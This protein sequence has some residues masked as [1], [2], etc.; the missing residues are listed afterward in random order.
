MQR[1]SLKLVSI[2]TLLNFLFTQGIAPSGGEILASFASVQKLAPASIAQS[3]MT[4]VRVGQV[5]QDWAAQPSIPFGLENQFRRY[6]QLKH[7]MIQAADQN[8]AESFRKMYRELIALV[9]HLRE[10]VLKVKD[11]RLLDISERVFSEIHFPAYVTGGHPTED[12]K[13]KIPIKNIR[14]ELEVVG[15]KELDSKVERIVKKVVDEVVKELYPKGAKRDQMRRQI[16]G[17]IQSGHL[18]HYLGDRLLEDD[19]SLWRDY[20]LITL[21]RLH[22][23]ARADGLMNPTLR[24]VFLNPS[25]DE[26]VLRCTLKHELVHYLALHGEIKIPYEWENITY[27]VDILER[28]RQVGEKG[29]DDYKDDF[30]VPLLKELF[31]RGKEMGL[32]GDTGFIVRPGVSDDKASYFSTD[33]LILEARGIYA[34]K[35]LNADHLQDFYQAQK[36]AGILL[37]GILAGMVEKDKE[38]KPL[39]LLRDFFF[40]LSQRWAPPP[41][42]EIDRIEKT[43]LKELKSYAALLSGTQI[44]MVPSETGLWR[45]EPLTSRKAKIHY[46]ITDLYPRP[47]DG[48][49]AKDIRSQREAARERGLG[50]ILL[51]INKIKY[52]KQEILEKSGDLATKPEFQVLWETLLTPNIILNAFSQNKE[53]IESLIIAE[54]YQGAPRWIARLFKDRYQIGNP[55]VEEALLRS[56]PPHLQF[57]DSLLYRWSRFDGKSVTL[58]DPR[59]KNRSVAQSILQS[60]GSMEDKGATGWGKLMYQPASAEDEELLLQV[61]TEKIWPIYQKLVEEALHQEE[62]RRAHERMLREDYDRLM[63]KQFEQLSQEQLKALE[64]YFNQLPEEVRQAIEQAAQQMM[65]QATQQYSQMMQSAQHQQGAHGLPQQGLEGEQSTIGRP[66]PT[67]AQ[68]QSATPTSSLQNVEQ[69]LK[70]LEQSLAGLENEIK[71]MAQSLEQVKG[72]TEQ[73]KQGSKEVS[74][75]GQDRPQAADQIADATSQI[76]QETQTLLDQGRDFNQEVQSGKAT[77]HSAAQQLPSPEQGKGVSDQFDQMGDASSELLD[78]IKNLMDQANHLK[79]L[80]DKLKNSLSEETPDESHVSAQNSAIKETAGKMEEGIRNIKGSNRDL[81]RLMGDLEKK[82]SQLQQSVEGG[83]QDG[84]TESSAQPQS[85]SQSQSDGEASKPKEKKDRA[86]NPKFKKE[87]NVSGLAQMAEK[88]GAELELSEEPE[89]GEDVPPL[90]LCKKLKA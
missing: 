3:P 88:F 13:L 14:R 59:V 84:A 33:I 41:K 15:Q 50:Q 36:E 66:T 89:T 23:T 80:A 2:I 72:G 38:L 10:E 39:A 17:D 76:Q 63:A 83:K 51:A 26:L 9:G 8:E 69:K 64:D 55:F 67:S 53:K 6:Y 24:K 4:Q 34:Q 16:L 78:K 21:S 29:L 65:Q 37:G 86:L 73:V 27:A 46:V 19:F 32:K 79:G 42:Q 18:E 52:G 48:K 82:V 22:E 31:L 47:V 12:G 81:E 28:V 68:T 56:L 49:E 90:F 70:N 11:E 71:Q 44:R 62:L 30:G 57:L 75:G 25:D 87:A 61:V 85:Q 45:Y 35:G 40:V 5:I 77:S 74:Q 58:K 43:L 60:F 54:K 1:L 7:E 20:V